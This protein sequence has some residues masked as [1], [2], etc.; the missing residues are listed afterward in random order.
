MREQ[1]IKKHYC[2]LSPGQTESMCFTVKSLFSS[3]ISLSFLFLCL[4]PSFLTSSLIHLSSPPFS[5][6]RRLWWVAP[7]WWWL[8][9]CLNNTA[10]C[11]TPTRTAELWLTPRR[12][13]TMLY[14]SGWLGGDRRWELER[15]WTHLHLNHLQTHYHYI[16]LLFVVSLFKPP[17][18][19]KQHIFIYGWN[20]S[21]PTLNLIWTGLTHM[22]TGHIRQSL[23]VNMPHSAFGINV[24]AASSA[25]SVHLPHRIII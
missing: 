7:P 10:L 14:T 1:F 13:A 3:L 11:W 24:C 4:P 23:W 2:S 9:S 12:A 21:W 15:T 18:V 6:P 20:V 22:L 16:A 5:S 25:D 8:W 19:M 17:W